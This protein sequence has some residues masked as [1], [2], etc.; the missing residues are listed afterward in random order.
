MWIRTSDS[1]GSII[2][3]RFDREDSSIG[4]DI[5]GGRICYYAHG[6]AHSSLQHTDMRVDDG[7]WHHVA[8]VKILDKLQLY[9]DGIQAGPSIAIQNE[10]L[11]KTPWHIGFMMVEQQSPLD[12]TYARIRISAIARYHFPFQPELDYSTDAATLLFR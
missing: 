3:K 7:I 11:S 9:V 4:L 1:D 12:A 8:A 5:E 2:T 6:P 10:N